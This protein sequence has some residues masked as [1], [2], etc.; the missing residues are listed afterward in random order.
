MEA[1]AQTLLATPD[2]LIEHCLSPE[3]GGFTPS[4][5]PLAGLDQETVDAPARRPAGEVEDVYP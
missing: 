5:F 2:A 4:D 1:L 3:A